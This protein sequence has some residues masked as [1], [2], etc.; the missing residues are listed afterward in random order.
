MIGCRFGRRGDNSAEHAQ[1]ARMVHRVARL[2]KTALAPVGL[3]ITHAS[4]AAAG[5]DVFHFHTHVIPRRPGDGLRPKWSSRRAPRRIS[6]Q[7][8]HAS[9]R[10]CEPRSRACAGVS[11]F[12]SWATGCT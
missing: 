4:G 3:S 11:V 5:Q 7:S 1:V 9:G 6:R 2:L 10:H 12:S 8:R